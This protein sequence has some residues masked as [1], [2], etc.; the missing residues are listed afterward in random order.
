MN[1]PNAQIEQIL[2]ALASTTEQ[3][4]A[5]ETRIAKLEKPLPG[6]P[7]LPGLPELSDAERLESERNFADDWAELMEGV[8]E[9][10]RRRSQPGYAERK[11]ERKRLLREAGFDV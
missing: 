4:K 2:T 7:N 8:A 1:D 9:H 10:R 11:A 3:L 5:L 6:L